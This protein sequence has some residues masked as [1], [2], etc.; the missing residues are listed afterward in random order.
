M[1]QGFRPLADAVEVTTMAMVMA[2]TASLPMPTM[3]PMPIAAI[4]TSTHC[5]AVKSGSTAQA[6]CNRSSSRFVALIPS[7]SESLSPSYSIPTKPRYPAARTI[8]II[9]L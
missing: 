7:G 9:R 6:P 5:R 1:R 3:T 2:I 8:F 4:T